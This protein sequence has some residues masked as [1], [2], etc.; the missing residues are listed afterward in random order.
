MSTAD[1]FLHAQNVSSKM[2][3]SPKKLETLQQTS[4][5]CFQSQAQ[6]L[7]KQK[8]KEQPRNPMT[9]LSFNMAVKGQEDGAVC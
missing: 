6:R 1:K 8:E 9:L 3:E 4:L 7:I 5:I 2:N